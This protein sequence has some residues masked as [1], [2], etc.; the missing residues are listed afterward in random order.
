MGGNPGV[1]PAVQVESS[2]PH[3]VGAGSH[4]NIQGVT[5]QVTPPRGS[6]NPNTIATRVY[7]RQSPSSGRD[8]SGVTGA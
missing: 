4:L 1:V 6:S 5:I 7:L 3:P 2:T 8:G